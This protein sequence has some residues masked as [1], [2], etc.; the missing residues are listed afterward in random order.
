MKKNIFFK[1][2]K[3]VYLSLFFFDKL[4]FRKKNGIIV[5][6]YH[7][8]SEDDWRYGVSPREFKAQID[9]LI[10]NYHPLSAEEFS[11][12]LNFGKNLSSPSFLLTFDDGY[13]DIYQTK[14]YL[15]GKG[16]KPLLFLLSNT[17]NADRGELKTRR[18]FLNLKEI[19][20]LILDG[21]TVGCHS[22]THKNF[23]NLSEE[24]AKKEILDAKKLL[25]EKLSLRITCFSYPKGVYREKILDIV[26][27]A[28]YEIA[29]SLESR[30][31]DLRGDPYKIPRIAIDRT[32]DFLEFKAAFS[33][34]VV[35]IRNLLSNTFLKNY[36]I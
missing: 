27:R 6:C 34:S 31:V 9:Y 16:I 8:V 36:L 24:E 35:K 14:D 1:I 12:Y 5:F 28:K 11:Y 15:K 25:E 22:A 30:F 21:W 10:E 33:P 32:Y 4:F 20:E 23:D 29:F 3:I 17:E 7:S 18:L 2:R 26:K 13:K 19:K